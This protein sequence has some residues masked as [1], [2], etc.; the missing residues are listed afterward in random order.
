MSVALGGEHSSQDRPGD[1][2]GR[3]IH[4]GLCRFGAKDGPPY[5]SLYTAYVL[6][7]VATRELSLTSAVCTLSLRDSVGRINV[8]NP[9]VLK[10]FQSFVGSPKVRPQRRKPWGE[11]RSSPL[12]TVLPDPRLRSSLASGLSVVHCISMSR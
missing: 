3:V 7:Q 4:N 9:V 10:P 11:A 6:S 5:Q 2:S 8:P 12:G 1:A